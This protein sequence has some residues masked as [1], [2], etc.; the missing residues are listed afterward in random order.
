MK[1]KHLKIEKQ[2]YNFTKSENR[3]EN[4]SKINI[5]IGANNS[6]K[7]RFMRYLF[8]RGNNNKLNFIPDEEKYNYFKKQTDKFKE[9]FDENQNKIFSHAHADALNIINKHIKDSP[10]Y[11]TESKPHYKELIDIYKNIERQH[12]SRNTYLYFCREIFNEYF[13]EL[14][15]DTNTFDYNFHKI[16]IPSLRGLIPLVPKDYTLENTPTDIC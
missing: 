15:F 1:I 2:E 14:E 8:Y 3:L 4:L 5:F 13:K 16:Y 7:S 12:P 9:F 10:T 6:G 11:L